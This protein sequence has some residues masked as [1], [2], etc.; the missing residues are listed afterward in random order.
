MSDRDTPI[1]GATAAMFN[2]AEAYELNMGRWSRRLAPLF[3]DFA[4]VR[5]GERILDV[6]CGTGS[7]SLALAEATMRSE[8][9]GVDRSAAFVEHARRRFTDARLRF[10]IASALNI[11]FPDACFDKSLSLLV[12]QLIP[13]AVEAAREMHRVTRPGGMAA[14]CTWDSRE[15]M[16][17]FRIF[18]DAATAL[19]PKAESLRE[20]NR[21]NGYR[22]NLQALWE[23]AGFES[24]A[25]KRLAIQM[26]FMGF[27][28][29][30]LPYLSGAGPASAY[31]VGLAKDH[32]AALRQLLRKRLCENESNLPFTLR[33]HAWAV[34]GTV[35]G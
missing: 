14:G 15:G 7:L 26:D 24:I 13:D 10:E 8:I 3:V 28:D 11:P 34:R 18:W 33:A 4:G 16:G 5:D 29:F 22:E 6:G 21:P 30:W 35:S 31:V 25:M 32:Q 9:V 17:L 27:D 19:D 20:T 12:L 1:V 2:D 23:S